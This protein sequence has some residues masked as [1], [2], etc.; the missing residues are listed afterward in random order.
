MLVR[1]HYRT[2]LWHLFP[3]QSDGVKAPTK[4][5]AHA[6]TSNSHHTWLPPL[7]L[8]SSLSNAWLGARWRSA[9]W[10]VGGLPCACG[11]AGIP[12]YLPALPPCPLAG[13]ELCLWRWVSC[14]AA[15][16]ITSAAL[17]SCAGGLGW[18]DRCDILAIGWWCGGAAAFLAILLTLRLW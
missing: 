17:Y 12:R 14:L 16:L 11:C 13:G 9:G 4:A 5:S 15:A 18:T 2:A 7:P 10:D 6:A 3:A 8:R 1:G